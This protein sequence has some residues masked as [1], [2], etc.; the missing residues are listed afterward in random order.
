VAAAL[1]QN[2]DIKGILLRFK[3][4][5]P[6]DTVLIQYVIKREHPEEMQPRGFISL[7]RSYGFSLL[8]TVATA[9]CG[10]LAMDTV[11]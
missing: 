3:S 5:N 2:P 6:L 7:Y 9:A 8:E 4:Q 10:V 1:S 11:Y